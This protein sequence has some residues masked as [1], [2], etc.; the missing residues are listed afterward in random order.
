MPDRQPESAFVNLLTGCQSA[1][2]AYIC[3]TTGKPDEAEDILQRTNV[4]LW[5][6]QDDYDPARDFLP[7]ARGIAR[8]EVLAWRRE[9]AGRDTL[10]SDDM[11]ARIE[12]RLEERS[13]ELDARRRALRLCLE[14]LTD[15][16]R[17]LLEDRYNPQMS[18]AQL[19]ESMDRPVK[20]VYQRL[21]RARAT[22]TKCVESTMEAD[23]T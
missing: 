8:F 9:S 21:F 10:L 16:Q 20:A 4:I 11:L 3:A 7:W 6:K 5:E 19:A 15:D 2:F 22:L 14:K 1:L 13:D 17:R 18:V 23:D 12:A